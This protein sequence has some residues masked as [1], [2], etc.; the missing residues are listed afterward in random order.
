MKKTE[1]VVAAILVAMCLFVPSLLVWG[2]IYEARNPCMEYQ[3]TGQTICSSYCTGDNDALLRHCWQT[4][5]PET[6]CVSRQMADGTVW[7]K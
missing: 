6:E 3:E 5:R 1:K 4:C 2:V 7:E